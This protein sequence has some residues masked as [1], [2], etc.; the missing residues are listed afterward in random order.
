MMLYACDHQTNGMASSAPAQEIASTNNARE[1]VTATQDAEKQRRKMAIIAI[2]VIL[3]L[4]F[5]PKK[6]TL[7][8]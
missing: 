5:W 8:E 3:A 2:V 4:A 7:W 6:S 1:L